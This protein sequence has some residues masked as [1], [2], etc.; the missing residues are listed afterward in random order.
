VADVIVK[1]G[2]KRVNNPDDLFFLV[3]CTQPG[4]EV[5]VE[6]V[7]EGRKEK[8]TVTVGQRQPQFGG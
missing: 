1:W 5:K 3:A 6:L 8:V 4:S 2:G 7:C